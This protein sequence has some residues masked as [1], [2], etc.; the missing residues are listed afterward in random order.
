ML[1]AKLGQT[2]AVQPTT[3]CAYLTAWHALAIWAQPHLVTGAA[4]AKED[5][6]IGRGVCVGP[7]PCLC[8]GRSGT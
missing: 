3:G 2:L 1:L 5:K 6:V 7:P 8:K 4:L